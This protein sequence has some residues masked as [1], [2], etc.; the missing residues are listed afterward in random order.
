MADAA[1]SSTDGASWLARGWSKNTRSAGGLSAKGYANK[2]A[3]CFDEGNISQAAAL[4]EK[5]F[6]FIKKVDMESISDPSWIFDFFSFYSYKSLI[7]YLQNKTIESLK[8]LN[9][10][11][12][13][14][15]KY[16]LTFHQEVSYSDALDRLRDHEDDVYTV[17][18]HCLDREPARTLALALTLLRKGRAIDELSAKMQRLK[19]LPHR[20]PKKEIESQ[21]AAL[22]RTQARIVQA[23]FMRDASHTDRKSSAARLAALDESL[24]DAEN[25]L[26]D[27]I[28]P[29]QALSGDGKVLGIDDIVLQV[30]ARLRGRALVE[31]VHFVPRRLPPSP[32]HP[33]REPAQYLALVLLPDGTVSAVNLGP[34]ST[35]EDAVAEF[36][37]VLAHP[38]EEAPP[39]GVDLA[40]AE[41]AGRTIQEQH[42]HRVHALIMA[43]V[44]DLLGGCTDLLLSP[45]AALNEVPFAALHDGNDFLI[46]T[47]RMN[48]LSS[49]RELLQRAAPAPHR[50]VF[51]LADPECGGLDGLPEAQAEARQIADLFPAERV[52]SFL[53]KEATKE[54]LLGIRGAGILHV[55]THGFFQGDGR[56]TDSGSRG[57]RLEEV[58]TPDP[59]Q[60][61][62]SS[63]P[64]L[65]AGLFMATSEERR[66][67]EYG[68]MAGL[69]SALEIAGMDLSGTELV[70]LSAC[71]SGVNTAQ[72]R[73]GVY[74]LRR[75]IQVAGAQTL[76][77][78]L[79]D[80]NDASTRAL[81]V[82]YYRR[83]RADQGR[84]DAMRAAMRT[85]RQTYAHPY[86]WA[87]FIVIGE[88]GPLSGFGD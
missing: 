41:Y 33:R 36:R 56:R 17:V 73:S 85:M 4:Q 60:L 19:N 69:T 1:A 37:H 21:L 83:L 24:R 10:S 65:R 15:E 77:S 49:G 25:D 78:S 80:V 47:Y 74:G 42:A 51:I 34:A 16:W 71:Q 81:M 70:T 31:F 11:V 53:G 5:A 35:I 32:Q 44:V 9:L 50:D 57:T 40:S 48:Y 14:S 75:A 29:E 38:G 2:A 23:S 82:E 86:Y 67:Q 7:E 64:M 27:L 20:Y 13:V 54:R 59:V 55:A 72:Q 87:P 76:V 6:D 3:E 26:A 88:D 52:Q 12:D 39:A 8:S 22:H 84:V 58:D 68:K 66:A 30:T 79:W 46:E 61:P 63:N 45:V 18:S 43:P 62:V 28:P